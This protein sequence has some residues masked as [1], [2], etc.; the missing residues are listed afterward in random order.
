MEKTWV[1]LDPRTGLHQ[2]W[3]FWLRVLDEVNRSARYGAPFGLLLM[4]AEVSATRKGDRPLREA[5]SAIAATIRTTDLGGLLGDGRVGVL[6]VSQNAESSRL[7]QQR[8]LAAT[9]AHG[10]PVRW[11]THLLS[12]P[13]DAATIS[14]LLTTG[15]EPASPEAQ[16]PA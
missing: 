16:R 14:T 12:Y 6:L 7:A 11:A 2:G 10:S 9:E 8:I 13:D 4:Q 15:W 5:V 1:P 3:Y